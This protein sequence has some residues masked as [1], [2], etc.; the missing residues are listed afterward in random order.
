MGRETLERELIE[1]KQKEVKSYA[2]AMQ[3]HQQV[4]AL[5]AKLHYLELGEE[6]SRERVDTAIEEITALE[7]EIARLSRSIEEKK[8]DLHFYLF[9]P[10]VKRLF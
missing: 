4:K 2:G 5:E 8:Q 10:S 7:Q 6:I 9:G 3:R 1:L